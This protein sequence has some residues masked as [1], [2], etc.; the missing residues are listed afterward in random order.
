MGSSSWKL[1]ERYVILLSMI[2]RRCVKILP[3]Y[4]LLGVAFPSLYRIK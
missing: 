1:L 3:C 2:L 4:N